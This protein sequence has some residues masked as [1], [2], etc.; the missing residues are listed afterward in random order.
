M[1]DRCSSPEANITLWLCLSSSS[2]SGIMRVA[3]PSP[4]SR[5]HMRMFFFNFS[6]K[7]EF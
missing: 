5:G 2:A 4:H 3:W 7:P 6:L 1:S